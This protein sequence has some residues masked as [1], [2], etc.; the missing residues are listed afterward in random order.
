MDTSKFVS[1]PENLAHSGHVANDDIVF[2]GSIT[3]GSINPDA[4]PR[5]D[6]AV[7]IG[8]AI[9]FGVIGRVSR[10]GVPAAVREDLRHH[11]Q[12]G[13]PACAMVLDWLDDLL[14]ADIETAAKASPLPR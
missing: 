3:T 11:A 5:T 6:P 1:G 8:L 9:R 12:A 7:L 4:L 2:R 14:L 13:E 10:Q